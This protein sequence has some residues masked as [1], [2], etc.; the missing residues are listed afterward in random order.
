MKSSLFVFVAFL[1]TTPG[2]IATTGGKKVEFIQEFR[3]QPAKG[4]V[5]EL[6]IPTPLDGTDYQTIISRD[7]TGN[8]TVVKHGPSKE[9][10][11]PFVYARWENVQDPVLQIVNVVSVSDRDALA[12]KPA[13]ETPQQIRAYL[14]PTKHVQTDGIVKE[15]ADKITTGIKDPDRK[16]RA[17]YHWIVAN[18]VRDPEV[19]G[20]GL[21]DVKSILASSH[22]KGKC[23]DLNSLFVGLAR[24]AG[25]PAREVFGQRV[26]AS[27]FSPALGKDGD[28]SKAQHC[29]AEFYS[30]AKKIWIPVDPADVRKYILEEKLT[31][32]HPQVKQL[33]DKFFG[34]WEGTWV[35]FNTARD[36]VLSGY[37]DQPIN[38]FMY[39][40]VARGPTHRPDG[41]DPS[42]VTYK[43]SS[44]IIDAP[45]KF[46]SAIQLKHPVTLKTAM[47]G[48]DRN[49]DN[50][51]LVAGSVAKVCQKKG[52]WMTIKTDDDSVRV[53]FKDYGF[54][55]PLNSEGQRV[56]MQGRLERKEISVK[57]QRHFLE[58][59]GAPADQIKAIT[60]PKVEYSFVASGVE[61]GAH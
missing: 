56:L 18:T 32:D 61:I 19:R 48:Y 23:T 49:K 60:T 57:D 21:G 16:A 12:Q 50:E 6:W 41:V 55:V 2:A 53:T 51:I 22:F 25:I 24:A 28:N 43:F 29:R 46:G 37:S 7:I 58:D 59:E 44:R 34:Y 1:G 31:T 4:E 42:E 40:L 33:A 26:T 13:S 17:I 39:P 38:Y 47:A 36:F 20:C 14:A 27:Q 3:P 15:T 52:C 30:Q 35:A 8:A 9:N 5:I 10:P 54:F 45:K 11:A